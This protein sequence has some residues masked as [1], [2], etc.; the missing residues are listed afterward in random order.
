M[1]FLVDAQLP[2]RL[3]LAISSAGHDA[4]HTLDL[5]NANRTTDTQ[6]KVISEA[7]ER[8]VM[9]KDSDFVDSLLLEGKPAKLLLISTGNIKNRELESLVLAQLPA[10][11]EAFENARF[12][13]LS[14]AALIIH[15]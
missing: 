4:I 5:T 1:K 15:S 7:E 9:S 14:R 13:E 6:I 11:G 12:V 10:I 8:I 3:A 2:R